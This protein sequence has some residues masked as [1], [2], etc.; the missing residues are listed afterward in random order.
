MPAWLLFYPTFNIC[1]ILYYLTIKCGYEVCI[2]SFSGLSDELVTC[3]I[4]LFITPFI[5][6]FLGM[7]FYEVLPQ[8]FGVRKHPLFCVKKIC[9][10]KKKKSVR[11]KSDD[12]SEDRIEVKSED[13]MDNEVLGEMKKVQEMDKHDRRSHPLVVDHLTKIYQPTGSKTKPKKALNA[14]NLVLNN[15]EIFGLLGPNGAGKTTFF[16]ML[17]GIYE[18]SSG[19]AWVGGHSIKENIAKVQELVGYCPQFDLLWEELSVEE[20][21]YFYSRLKNVQADSVRNVKYYFNKYIRTLKEL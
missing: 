17:T 5:Y 3:L 1:R 13:I 6:M 21:L 8:Q 18:P 4:V 20:H 7:Y 11:S 12:I 15:N 16:S 14:L 9:K 19:E 10:K 2:G